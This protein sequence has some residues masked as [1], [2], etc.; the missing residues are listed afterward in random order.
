MEKGAGSASQVTP[1]RVQRVRVGAAFVGNIRHIS[2]ESKLTAIRETKANAT[3][4]LCVE[5][6]KPR[7]RGRAASID[8]HDNH[9]CDMTRVPKVQPQHPTFVAAIIA[10]TAHHTTHDHP[11]IDFQR[12]VSEPD[13]NFCHPKFEILPCKKKRKI[14]FLF[15]LRIRFIAV[16]WSDLGTRVQDG[17]TKGIDIGD[18][19]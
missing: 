14:Y 18:G 11:L 4:S 10:P 7:E 9:V 19:K 8:R 5:G 3:N 12:C 17:C 15:E 2:S 13:S 6:G 1:T 16:R